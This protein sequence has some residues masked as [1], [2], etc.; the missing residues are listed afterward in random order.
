MENIMKK[1]ITISDLKYFLSKDTADFSAFFR[2]T[3]IPG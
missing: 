2:L 3:F 1:K